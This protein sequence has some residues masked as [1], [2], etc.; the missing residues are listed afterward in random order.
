MEALENA[1]LDWRQSVA[2]LSV[3]ISMLGICE[4]LFMNRVK[5]VSKNLAVCAAAVF[6]VLLASSAGHA[7][8]WQNYGTRSG[9]SYGPGGGLSTAPCG[10]QSFAPCP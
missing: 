3:Q 9:Q 10:G 2:L 8:G 6:C 1:L 4:M 5:I 7:Q